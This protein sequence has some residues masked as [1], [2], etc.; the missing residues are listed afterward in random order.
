MAKVSN[1][2][3]RESESERDEGAEEAGTYQLMPVKRSEHA[4]KARQ[5]ATCPHDPASSKSRGR[6]PVRDSPTPPSGKLSVKKMTTAQMTVPE[7]NA[8]ERR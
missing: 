8:A 2:A 6:K 7:S 4:R 5:S 3:E 1:G